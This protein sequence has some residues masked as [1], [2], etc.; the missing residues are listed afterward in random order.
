MRL[1]IAVELDEGLRPKVLEVENRIKQCGGDV[2]LVEPQNLHFTLKFLGEVEEGRVPEIEDKIRDILED[3]KPF[4]IS[5]EGFGYFGSPRY[6]KTLWIDVKEGK[7]QLQGLADSLNTALDYIRHEKHKGDI[8][9]TVGRVKSAKNRDALLREIEALKDVKVGEMVVKEVKL[10]Q[11]ALNKT[12][13][14]YSDVKV[15]P[16]SG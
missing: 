15:F 16:L 4:T 1:F 6:L 8:H 2:K 12:G 10:K 5:I 7:E 9:L 13:P 3:S 11:S 14:V